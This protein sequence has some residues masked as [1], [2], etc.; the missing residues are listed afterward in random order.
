MELSIS[1]VDRDDARGTGLEEAVREA[2]RRRADVGAD[3]V[4]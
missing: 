2:P 1:D 3:R 4:P